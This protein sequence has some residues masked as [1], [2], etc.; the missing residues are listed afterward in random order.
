MKSLSINEFFTR[1]GRG[2]VHHG[3]GYGF[4]RRVRPARARRPLFGRVMGDALAGA[5]A[6][7][8]GGDGSPLASQIAIDILKKGGSAVDAAIAA[9]AALGLMEPV[10]NGIGGD[11]FAIVWDPKTKKLYGYNGSGRSAKGRDLAKMVARD[12]S[13]STP[14]RASPTSRIFRRYG[15]LADH[16]AGHG[17]RVGRAA[18]EVRQVAARRRPR[19]GHRLRAERLSGDAAHRDLLERQHGRLR[20]QMRP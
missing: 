13:R 16:R 14:K 6:A 17:R 11:L 3:H 1:P 10:S 8:H 19:A 9:N 12:R 2:S 18:C 4:Q 7:R 5:G 20:A 15:S